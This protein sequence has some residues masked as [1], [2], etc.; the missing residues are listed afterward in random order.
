M[1][2]E[3]TSSSFSDHIAVSSTPTH[4]KQKTM[5]KRIEPYKCSDKFLIKRKTDF[6]LSHMDASLSTAYTFN[7][8]I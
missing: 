3:M 4:D 5:Q 1:R 6:H 2:M 8:S 7:S